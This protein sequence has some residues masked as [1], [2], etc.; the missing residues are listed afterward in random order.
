MTII[1]ALITSTF[2]TVLF[3]IVLKIM[4]VEFNSVV[5]KKLFYIWLA[6]FLIIYIINTISFN[7]AISGLM[8]EV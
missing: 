1:S 8:G 3:F 2:W 5:K 6:L 7:G 4:K